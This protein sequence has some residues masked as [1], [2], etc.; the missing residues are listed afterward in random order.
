MGVI[1]CYI[2]INFE[3]VATRLRLPE[4]KMFLLGCTDDRTKHVS[5]RWAVLTT[6]QNM[7]LLG[8]SDD[9]TNVVL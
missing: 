4:K 6:A 3:I 9:R 5:V 7:F 2:T 8:C 1:M